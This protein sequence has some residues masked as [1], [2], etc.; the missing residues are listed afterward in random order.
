M[1]A[2]DTVVKPKMVTRVQSAIFNLFI[3][4]PLFCM[5][6]FSK[7]NLLLIYH[8]K[9]DLKGNNYCKTIK[10]CIYWR[11]I[12]KISDIYVTT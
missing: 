1:P 4:I 9:V 6:Y 2:F 5:R 3:Y 10:T 7:I 12:T 11:K 8:F